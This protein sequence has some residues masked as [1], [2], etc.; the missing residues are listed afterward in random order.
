MKKIILILTLLVSSIVSF[1]QD[2]YASQGYPL[3]NIVD[4]YAG[5]DAAYSYTFLDNNSKSY[6]IAKGVGV[7]EDYEDEDVYLK[8]LQ[9]YIH[10]GVNG[11][12]QRY[13]TPKNLVINL[14]VIPESRIKFA[15]NELKKYGHVAVVFRRGS[16]V[17]FYGNEMLPEGYA[18]DFTHK[19]AF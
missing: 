15:L 1:G 14:D 3:S 19:G 5:T 17:G 16:T 8:D 7:F 13:Y 2:F 18:V 6:C 12:D 9:C 11:V 10:Y 4:Y